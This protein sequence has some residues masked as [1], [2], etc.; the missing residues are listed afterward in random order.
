MRLP[1]EAIRWAAVML[2][3]AGCAQSPFR[4]VPD[5][6]RML[7]PA[8]ALASP[9]RVGET[10]LWGGRIVGVS[11]VDG[12]T[13]LEVLAL[14]LKRGDRPD[15]SA[16]G[17][18]RFIVRHPG[19]LEPMNYAPGR[20]VTVLGEFTGI[21][22]RSVGSFPLDMP[23]LAARRIQLWP[24]KPNAPRPDLHIGIGVRF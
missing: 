22:S 4:E 9:E 19:F 10:V 21:E 5:T 11:P 20:F 24:V 17:S 23:V 6:A 2:L 3:V 18:L 7:T 12:H 1:F 13:E 14:P 15:R 8:Q 16:D